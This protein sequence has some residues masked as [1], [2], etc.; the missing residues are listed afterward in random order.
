MSLEL[1]VRRHSRASMALSWSRVQLWQRE[2]CPI[3]SY[4]QNLLLLRRGS[5]S[6]EAGIVNL[7]R[8]IHCREEMWY[9]R[10]ASGWEVWLA[11]KRVDAGRMHRPRDYAV[12]VVNISIWNN[13]LSQHECVC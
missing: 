3:Q 9:W 8:W 5:W 12:A 2:A 11:A 4:R 6:L 1:E 10:G 7:G 13:V